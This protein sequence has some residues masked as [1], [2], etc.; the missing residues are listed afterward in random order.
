M[1]RQIAKTRGEMA[2]GRVGI[3]VRPDGGG[4]YCRAG[5]RR[6]DG[7]LGVE[8]FCIVTRGEDDT[9]AGQRR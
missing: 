5:W 6:Q 9:S 8:V 1:G 3:R 7:V 2:W 4:R